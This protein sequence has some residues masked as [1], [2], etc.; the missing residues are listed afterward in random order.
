MTNLAKTITIFLPSG[1]PKELKEVEVTNRTI[2]AILIPR[3]NLDIAEKRLKGNNVGTYIL[4]GDDDDTSKPIAYI[5]EAEDC[6]KRLKQHNQDSNKE[7]WTHA[8][9]F[10]SKT[11][12]LTKTEV[13]WLESF[14]IKQAMEANRYKLKNKTIPSVPHI[15]EQREA[16]LIDNFETIKIL[17]STLNYPL[18]D[19]IQ[20]SKK[21]KEIYECKGKL[22][23]AKGNYLS[24]GLLVLKGSKANFDETRTIDNGT[25][26]LRKLLVEDKILE[27]KNG[28]LIFIEDYLFT[29]LSKASS[30]ILGR[31][32]NG[33]IDWKNK[34]GK[35]LD[36]LKRK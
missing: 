1:N 16:D 28:V 22:A 25:R 9:I 4:F 15:T 33:W 20:R 27:E 14:F 8:V 6:L 2:K 26:K 30:V 21:S 34:N 24:E 32:S 19:K 5:G 13:K 12:M 7:F 11:N 23:D 29:S 31:R 17:L 35:T 18:F 3:F 36:E 10:T